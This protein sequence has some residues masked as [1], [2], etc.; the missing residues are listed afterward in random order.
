MHLPAILTKTPYMLRQHGRRSWGLPAP[1]SRGRYRRN[2]RSVGLQRERWTGCIAGAGDGLLTPH[3]GHQAQSPRGSQYIRINSTPSCWSCLPKVSSNMMQQ[4]AVDQSAPRPR[5]PPAP[6][7]ERRPFGD[8]AASRGAL[9]PRQ[10][11]KARRDS[12]GSTRAQDLEAGGGAGSAPG[13]Q[14]RETRICKK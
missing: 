13:D 5:M 6:E 12:A 14:L 11:F 1:K 8:D 7:G 10:I 9:Q 4:W 3:F 2:V